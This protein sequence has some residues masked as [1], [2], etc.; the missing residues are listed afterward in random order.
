M[1]IK[2]LPL[3]VRALLLSPAVVLFASAT[4]LL[5]ICNYNAAVATKLAASG[6]IVQTLL[7]TII[8]LLPPYLP[9]LV[10]VLLVCRQWKVLVLAAF[11]MILVSPV[12]ASLLDGVRSGIHSLAQLEKHHSLTDLWREYRWQMVGVFVTLV[13]ALVAAP[14]R[15]RWKTRGEI[16]DKIDYEIKRAEKE[17]EFELLISDSWS[18]AGE[19]ELRARQAAHEVMLGTIGRRWQN[20]RRRRGFTVLWRVLYGLLVA[21]V[22]STGFIFIAN[23]YSIPLTGDDVS[24]ALHT[25]WLP[26]ERITLKNHSTDVGYVLST[27]DG[28]FTVLDEKTRTIEYIAGDE[29][30]TRTV[31]SLPR[32]AAPSGSPII[33]LEG[34][35]TSS[36]EHCFGE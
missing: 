35:V 28:W 7:G 17:A 11:A 30:E 18:I 34:T 2:R 27:N 24:T 9:L 36:P 19:Q 25:P 20:A 22:A 5:L 26:P 23:L 14:D 4:R 6:G 12:H 29:V 3:A 33:E 8:P 1:R 21:L 16:I 32:L 10:L 13:L 31:C 15:F